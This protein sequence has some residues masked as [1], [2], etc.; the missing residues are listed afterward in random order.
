MSLWHSRSVSVLSAFYSQVQIVPSFNA[1][2]KMSRCTGL[3][4]LGK[5]HDFCQSGQSQLLGILVIFRQD[6]WNSETRHD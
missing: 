3:P 2:C 5:V 6:G 4:F 1:L